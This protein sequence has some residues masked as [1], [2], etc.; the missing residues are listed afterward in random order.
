MNFLDKEINYGKWGVLS[1]L[2]NCNLLGDCSGSTI[3]RRTT[4][5]FKKAFNLNMSDQMAEH[6]IHG[7]MVF[8]FY[9][10]VLK[11]EKQ[12]GLGLVLL[13]TLA[14]FYSIGE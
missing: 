2:I 5:G 4:K 14:I 6:I 1:E 13:F 3:S 9:T 10:L 7:L 11:Q 12:I 8:V